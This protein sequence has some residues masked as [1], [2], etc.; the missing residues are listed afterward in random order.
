MSDILD[1]LASHPVGTAD[2]EA[3]KRQLAGQMIIASES[4]ENTALS[5]GRALLRYGSVATLSQRTEMLMSVT[6]DD[7]LQAASDL[8]PALISRLSLC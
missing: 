8:A 7:L 6:A 2:L 1:D 4:R 3:A 5:A